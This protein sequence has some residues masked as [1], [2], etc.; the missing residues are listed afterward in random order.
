MITNQDDTDLERDFSVKKREK[1]MQGL[2]KTVTEKQKPRLFRTWVYV[3]TF[4]K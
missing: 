3:V 2:E 4:T 1:P